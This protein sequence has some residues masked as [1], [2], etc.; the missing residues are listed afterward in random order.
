MS[1]Q[2]VSNIPIPSHLPEGIRKK[3][4][5]HN[6]QLEEKNRL[7]DEVVDYDDFTKRIIYQYIVDFQK[8]YP[9]VLSDEELF[10]RLTANIKHNIRLFKRDEFPGLSGAF[11]PSKHEVVLLDSLVEDGELTPKA[12]ATLFH[13]LTHALVI[14][15]PFDSRIDSDYVENSNFIVESIVTIMEEDYTR[16]ILNIH[17]GLRVNSYIPTYARE[18]RS[19]FGNELIKEYIV[20]FRDISRLFEEISD[21]SFMGAYSIESELFNQID[22]IY[23][24]IKGKDD[25]VNI[26]FMS[27]NIELGIATLLDKYLT[28][29]KFSDM[30]ALEKIVSLTK[31]QNH[32]NFDL[33]QSMIEKHVSDKSLIED[34]PFAKALYFGN[35]KIIDP[36]DIS[37]DSELAEL[38]IKLENFRAS[39]LF[40]ANHYEVEDSEMYELPTYN[41]SKYVHYQ[42]NKYLYRGLLELL[43]KGFITSDD[44]NHFHRL[45]RVVDSTEEELLDLR[46]E[47]GLGIPSAH[48][49]LNNSIRFGE[50]MYR[51]SMGDKDF[52]LRSDF[53][54]E[55]ICKHSV[56]DVYGEYSNLIREEKDPEMVDLYRQALEIVADLI[57]HGVEEVYS[58]H[59]VLIYEKDGQYEFCLPCFGYEEDSDKIE[60]SYYLKQKISLIDVPGPNQRHFNEIQK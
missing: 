18:L 6:R 13:E 34:N 1:E 31:L 32:V 12:K 59:N 46:D 24:A 45:E 11:F 2:I 28:K 10:A 38:L 3:L 48:I 5:Q 47:L 40:G 21:D 39:R 37:S 51:C 44:M 58:G 42:T 23:Y 52:F 54:N 25:N 49:R 55:I 26:E 14:N 56:V 16:E 22:Q 33:Y 17:D 36:K 29:N 60:H 35:R 43:E 9:G 53:E 20:K 4:E 41:E 27:H 30:D 8:L 19:I 50:T 7:I 15:N 57:D